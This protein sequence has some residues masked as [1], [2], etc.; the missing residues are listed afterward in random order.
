MS[1]TWGEQIT[2]PG[3]KV[4][5][6]L[7]SKQYCAVK[8][9]STA[10]VIVAVTASTDIAVGILQDAPDAANEAAT[11]AALGVTVAIAGTSDLA[12]GETV[13]Y[14]TTGQVQDGYAKAIGI[15]L[16]ASTAK[17]QQVRVLLTGL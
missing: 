9:A 17:L 14:N 8:M 2:I 12:A 16:E 15:A 3:L 13:G 11:V 6:D 1:S 10:N 4:G 7:S 5:A